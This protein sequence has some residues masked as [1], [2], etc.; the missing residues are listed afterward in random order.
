MRQPNLA[1]LCVL[2]LS[3]SA[4]AQ[5][6]QYFV[7]PAARPGGKIQFALV[8]Q[9]GLPFA[10][11]I[12]LR[13]GPRVFLGE[14]LFL[15][16][17]P[18]L[19]QLDAGTFGIG[20]LH[21]RSVSIPRVGVPAGVVFYMQSLVLDG[22]AR[23]GIFRVSN[24]ESTVLYTSSRVMVE[25]FTDPV[26]SGY[27]G[28]FDKTRRH[29]LQGGAIARRVHTIK[30]RQGVRFR[31]PITGP[32]NPDGAR[33]QMVYRA[34][35]LGGRGEREVITAVR[36]LPFGKVTTAKFKRMVL[37]IGHTRVVP[38]YSI[39]P[40][41]AFPRFPASGLNSTFAKNPKPGEVQTRIIDGSY[42][43]QAKDVRSDGYLGYPTPT[44]HFVYNG[45]DSLLLDIKMEAT[46]GLK[47]AN[48][49]TIQLMVTSSP[50]PD[51]RVRASGRPGA[52]LDP[53]RAATGRGDNS[54]TYMQF[55][56]ARVETKASSPWRKAPVA[57]PDYHTP[58]LA[59]STPLGTSVRVEYRG[60]DS[61]TGAGTTSWATN[62]NFVDRKQYLQYRITFT[63]N[64]RTG[65]VPSL[66]AIVI[67]IN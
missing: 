36:W 19:T 1:S 27:A 23:N 37:D 29:R 44:K 11:F 61:A 38:D 25:E 67:P 43:I 46:P 21:V 35:D 6:P 26:L 52:P 31:L 30:P 12:D 56:F 49:Q 4:A 39:N 22:K 64:P 53:H 59:K 14:E 60:A 18:A 58:T 63:G 50:R 13:G 16:L 33:V 48:G 42:T 55:E 28:T 47:N 24:G 7:T 9:P 10:S 65:A 51:S 40:I 3:L 2:T 17:T 66:E 57:R 32:L 34:V 54:L 15:G 45:A 5:V 8:G 62:V 41:T 20:G